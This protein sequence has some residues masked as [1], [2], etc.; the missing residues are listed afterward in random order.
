MSTARDE[1]L[2]ETAPAPKE[3]ELLT[4]RCRHCGKI[5]EGTLI[6]PSLLPAAET[7]LAV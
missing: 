1:Q 6:T 5:F 3:E 2:K 4:L 7:Y